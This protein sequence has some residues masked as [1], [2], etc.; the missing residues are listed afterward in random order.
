MPT[1]RTPVRTGDDT[2]ADGPLRHRHTRS[3]RTLAFRWV[4]LTATTVTLAAHVTD[5]L[6]VPLPSA[7]VWDPPIAV[8][9][10]AMAWLLSQHRDAVLTEHRATREH[11]TRQNEA[12][13]ADT[14]E[15]MRAH[16]EWVGGKIEVTLPLAANGHRPPAPVLDLVHRNG[17]RD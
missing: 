7:L 16:R 3:A 8:V 13:R 17:H 10:A 6:L 2:R 1:D 5:C 11:I 14:A 12:T 15:L 9:V 4:F